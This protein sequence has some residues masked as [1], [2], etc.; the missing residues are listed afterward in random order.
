MLAAGRAGDRIFV[1]ISFHF[2]W[3]ESIHG[4][5]QG[6]V[7]FLRPSF[8]DF[9]STEA[10]FAFLAVHKRIGK[11]ANVAGSNPYL[12]VHQNSRIK[13]DIIG[14]FLNKLFPPGL[15]YVVFQLYAQRAV[16][17]CVCEAAVNFGARENEAAIFAERDDFI[18]PKACHM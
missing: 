2:L 18:H 10:F 3:G 14:A 1:D 16:V 13:A 6:N 7:F 12:R 17:P 8:N 15:F 5:G 4:L 9:V 11:P